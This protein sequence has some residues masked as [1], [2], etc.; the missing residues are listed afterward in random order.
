[1]ITKL[2]AA[3]GADLKDRTFRVENPQEHRC[4]LATTL[5][6]SGY[7]IANRSYV[8]KPEFTAISD[9]IS[10]RFYEGAAAGTVMIGETAEEKNSRAS[11][12]ARRDRLNLYA[13]F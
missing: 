13:V 12:F 7:Y 3:G 5:R 11:S 10:A 8:N 6:H 1:M 4:M 2:L 9:E